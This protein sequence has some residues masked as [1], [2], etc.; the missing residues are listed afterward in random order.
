M[1]GLRG[2][3]SAITWAVQRKQQTAAFVGAVNCKNAFNCKTLPSSTKG[4]HT[5]MHKQRCS[6]MLTR[7]ICI[8]VLPTGKT[9]KKRTDG[10]HPQLCPYLAQ[11]TCDLCVLH[12]P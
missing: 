4:S 9:C 6:A 10:S 12:L 11:Q 3:R 1:R 5:D 8:A 2:W 7:S